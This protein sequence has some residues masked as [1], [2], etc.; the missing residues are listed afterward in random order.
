MVWQIDQPTAKLKSAIIKSFLYC[1][2]DCASHEMQIGGCGLRAPA[3]LI[4]GN[5]DK[6]SL[7][8]YFAKA[9]KPI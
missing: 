7:Y 5:N 6:M 3:Q 1:E 8:R 4:L 9:G 2:H